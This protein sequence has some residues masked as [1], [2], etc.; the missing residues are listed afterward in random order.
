MEPN[1]DLH[2]ELLANVKKHGLSDTY[3]IVP[4]GIED[5]TTLYKYGVVHGT[6]DTVMSVQVLCGV[7]RPAQVAKEI[8]K[9][10]KPGGQMIVYEHVMSEDLVSG[11]VQRA[12]GWVWPYATGNCHLDRPTGEYLLGAGSWSVVELEAP[13]KED[14]WTLFPHIT[15]RLVKKGAEKH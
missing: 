7:P 15:G 11:F 13:E 5:I 3:T 2:P 12:Y 9:L 1:T 14:H 8:Y 4:C 6:I 10:L